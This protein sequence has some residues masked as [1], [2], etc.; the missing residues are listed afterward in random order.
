M[1]VPTLVSLVIFMI[2]TVLVD[3]CFSLAGADQLVKD[4][5]AKYPKFIRPV[6]NGSTAVVIAHRMTP[7][8]IVDLDEKGQVIILKSWCGQSWTDEYLRWNESKYDGI[9][10]IQLPID[11]VWQPDITLYGSV[12]EEF[13]RH[14]STDISVMSSGR[15]LAIQPHVYKASCSVDATYFPFDHQRCLFKFGSWS[16]P[17]TLIDIVPDNK[18]NIDNFI[19]NGEWSVI[20][21][22]IDRNVIFFPCCPLPFSDVTYTI[23]IRRHSLFYVF[24]IIFPAFLV[25]VLVVV[26]FYLPSDSGE[27]ITLSVSSML[28]LMVFL[29]TVSDYMPPNSERIPYLQLYL[30]VTIALV[31]LSC[32]TTALTLNLHF[33]GAMIRRAPPCLRAL[34]FRGLAKILR[35]EARLKITRRSSQSLRRR[36]SLNLL[37]R[38]KRAEKRHKIAQS[39]NE[40][41]RCKTQNELLNLQSELMNNG[42]CV[43][44][45]NDTSLYSDSNHYDIACEHSGNNAEDQVYRK[46][47][48]E[49][50][51]IARL[52]DRMF[53]W[54]YGL[55]VIS[56]TLGIVVFLTCNLGEESKDQL[57][58]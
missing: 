29:S 10:E 18:S 8:Q 9:N 5:L 15:V 42:N 25:S 32:V 4:V 11:E 7:I 13:Q 35:T 43:G 41:S 16:Y 26:G 12:N 33:R 2:S 22:I 53:L 56:L 48:Q 58:F 39:Q 45:D 54:I 44:S 21:M 3:I 49:W 47:L 46:W 51:E 50:K 31:V 36:L 55:I 28:T 14:Y 37:T 52:L 6:I 30:F 20:D 23:H 19:S 38:R 27:R 34:A 57:G 1:V 24:N 40:Y 17:M